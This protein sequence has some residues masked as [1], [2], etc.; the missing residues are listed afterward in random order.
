MSESTVN[1]TVEPLVG[2]TA[3][4]L[5]IAATYAVPQDGEVTS[6]VE[7]HP[8]NIEIE[9]NLDHHPGEELTAGFITE[10]V[11]SLFRHAPAG[12][13]PSVNVEAPAGTY[14]LPGALTSTAWGASG[15][16]ATGTTTGA[17]TEVAA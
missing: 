13:T 4:T 5:R 10:I 14:T 11:A 2:Y 8:D 15:P 17:T 1:N 9:L 16:S 12:V 6:P 3:P 7:G